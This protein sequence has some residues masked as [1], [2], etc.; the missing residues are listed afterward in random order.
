MK[1]TILLAVLVAPS[2]VLGLLDTKIKAKGKK[3]IG[4]A[5]DP[6]TFSISQVKTIATSDFGCYSECC[7]LP[8]SLRVLLK[9]R[10]F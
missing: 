4:T 1:S 10:P 3:Y 8:R 9:G 2:A 5:I 6:N 7:D